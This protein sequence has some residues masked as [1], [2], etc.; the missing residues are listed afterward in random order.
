VR[1]DLLVGL[2]GR[3]EADELKLVPGAGL[4]DRAVPARRLRRE[5]A[6]EM[7]D[8]GQ[9]QRRAGSPADVPEKLADGGI[10]QV[11]EQLGAHPGRQRRGGRA[12]QRRQI[13]GR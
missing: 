4:A 6:A 7:A 1:A 12:G 2:A 3:G 10:G 11:R 13:G 9:H 5:G 8:L